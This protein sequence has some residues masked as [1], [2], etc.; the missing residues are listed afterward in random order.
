MENIMISL[1]KSLSVWG[2]ASAAMLGTV[3]ASASPSSGASGKVESTRFTMTPLA[4]FV[5]CMAAD[6][7]TAPRIN[8]EVERGKLNDVLKI[9][10][11]GFKPGMQFDLFTIENSRLDA[12]GAL[13]PNFKGFGMSWYQSD[14]EASERGGI[15]ARIRT[16][17]LDQ[18]FGFIDGGATPVKPTNTFNVGFWFNNPDDAKNCGFTGATPFNGEHQAGPLAFVT[19]PN[20]TTHLGPLCTDPTDASSATSACN[21]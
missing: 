4:K 12:K 10:G 16:I 13:D 2:I 19:L 9:D 15:H 21:P 18:I 14:L 8:V 3:V 11:W 1:K 20:A 5:P 17:L 7:K 6:G